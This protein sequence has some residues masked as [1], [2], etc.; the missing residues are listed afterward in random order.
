M[1]P[2]R[3]GYQQC[4]GH[5]FVVLRRG[6]SGGKVAAWVSNGVRCRVLAWEGD[7]VRVETEDASTSVGCF[8][9]LI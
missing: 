5:D 4:D 6:P 3:N 8:A 9:V 1:A 7:R 2:V